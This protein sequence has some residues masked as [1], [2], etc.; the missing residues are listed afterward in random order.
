MPQRKAWRCFASLIFFGL[1]ASY[2]LAQT[3]APTSSAAPQYS[4]GPI[5]DYDSAVPNLGDVLRLRRG[6]RYNIPIPSK[7]GLG[8]DSET[9]WDLPATHFKKDPMPVGASDAVVLGTVS[10]GQAYLS[11]DRRNIYS[12]FKF[13]IREIIKTPNDLYLQ[14]HDLID[15]HRKGSAIRLQSG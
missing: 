1:G 5:T 9:E 3:S 8:E 11:N 7:P 4:F 15:I 10:A 14:T 13:T 2:T 12:E 6:E